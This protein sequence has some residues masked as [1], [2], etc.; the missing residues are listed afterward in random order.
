M[1]FGKLR[2]RVAATLRIIAGLRAPEK[3]AWPPDCFDCQLEPLRCW[4]SSPVV[5]YVLN[6]GSLLKSKERQAL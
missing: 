6:R 1:P 3:K 4:H 5:L 2:E